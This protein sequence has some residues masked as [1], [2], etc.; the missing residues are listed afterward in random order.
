MN[1]TD[2][3]NALGKRQSRKIANHT[4]IRRE[5]AVLYVRL[6]ETDVV[7]LHPDGR[8]ILDSGGYHT[9]TTKDRIDRFSPVRLY[10]ENSIWYIASGKE[11]FEKAVFYDGIVIGPDGAPKYPVKGDR[12]VKRV[13]ETKRL[14]KRYCDK[15]R[16]LDTLP[17]PNGGDCWYCLLHDESGESMGEL[18]RDTAH[19]ATHLKDGYVF[20][21]LILNALKVAGYTSPE[22]IWQMDLRDRIVRAV[23]GY[24]YK[25]LGIAR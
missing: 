20:G 6:H 1:Y 7:T 12:E 13:L 24:F 10:Q 3:L 11:W 25:N 2:V 8:V 22:T 14:V 4:Y 23:R 18:F 5:G 21:S 9:P 17:A 19:L 16:A 15:I